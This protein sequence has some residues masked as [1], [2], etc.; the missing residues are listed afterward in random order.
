LLD[1]VLSALDGETE[2][3]VFN[4]LFGSPDGL[5]RRMKTTVLL[6]L[7]SGKSLEATINPL[8]FVFHVDIRLRYLTPGRYR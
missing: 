2:T 5:F 8:S 4:N 3:K 1:D 7:N 6:V